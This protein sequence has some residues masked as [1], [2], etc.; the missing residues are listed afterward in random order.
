ML[1]LCVDG[2]AF[3]CKKKQFIDEEFM[4]WSVGIFW[5]KS[6]IASLKARCLTNS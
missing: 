5:D 4:D 2:T 6:Y 3:L 1:T